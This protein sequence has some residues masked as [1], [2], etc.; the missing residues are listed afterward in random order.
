MI[1]VQNRLRLLSGN[2]WLMFFFIGYVFAACSPK[3]QTITVKP[4]RPDTER[5]VAKARPYENSLVKKPSSLVSNIALLLP[6][7]LD[8]L[9]PGGAFSTVTF[10]EADIAL[11]YY[12]GFKLGLDSLTAQG[13]NYKL[14]VFDS[15]DEIAQAHS[16]A[17][18]PAVRSSDLIVGPV[19]PDGVKTFTSTYTNAKQPIVSPLSPSSPSAYNNR[20]LITV[21]PPLEYHAYTTA[22]Y[23]VDKLKPLKV[24]ILRSGFSDENEYLAPFMKAIDSLSKNKIKIIAITVSRGQLGALVRQLNTKGRNVFVMPAKDQHFL[25]VTMRS[26]DTLSKKYPVTLFGHPNW[27]NYMYLNIDLL[28]RLNTYITSADNINYKESNTKV[29]MQAY[30]DS[31]HI[32]PSEYSVKG[33]DEGYYLG[34][35]LATNSFKNLNDQD[36]SGIHNAFH[37]INKP[38][39]GWVNTHV[40]IYKYSNFELKKVE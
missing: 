29:F 7:G 21:M 35:V 14:Q 16:L 24:F 8:H 32:E 2:R 5:P 40:N 6:F 4:A 9:A 28:Q 19:F 27:V 23:I 15:R 13:Y 22:Q 26:L 10:K 12:R 34:H 1:S 33:F 36:Y 11:D 30:R 3:V 38:G 39:A 25:M 31:Y 37:F 18:N 17:T 20:A